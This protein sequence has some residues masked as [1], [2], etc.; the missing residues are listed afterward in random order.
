M[1][2]SG[3]TRISVAPIHE[4]LRRDHPE[5]KE[6]NARFVSSRV[7]QEFVFGVEDLK[8]TNCDEAMF[9][10]SLGIALDRRRGLV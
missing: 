2:T 5:E 8:A 1:I 10:A 7:F 4:N 6:T 3:T 9:M